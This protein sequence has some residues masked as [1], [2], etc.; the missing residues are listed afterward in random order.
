MR[1][2]EGCIDRRG[3]GIIRGVQ[4]CV[5]TACEVRVHEGAQELIRRQPLAARIAKDDAWALRN[6]DA[7]AFDGPA[8]LGQRALRGL[9]IVYAIHEQSGAALEVIGQEQ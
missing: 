3:S 9:E 8:V 2:S 7:F 6:L 5:E 4:L 1:V